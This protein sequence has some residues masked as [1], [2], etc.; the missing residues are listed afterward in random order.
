MNV[1]VKICKDWRCTQVYRRTDTIGQYTSDKDATKENRIVAAFELAETVRTY[2][3]SG[4]VPDPIYKLCAISARNATRDNFVPERRARLVRRYLYRTSVATARARARI[5]QK[6][7]Y[8]KL[9]RTVARASIR[10]TT[11]KHRDESLTYKH[12]V[13]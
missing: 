12:R 1:V 3:V 9:S 5:I 4:V 8:T 11:D 7:K 10:P 13:R 2:V 6:Q